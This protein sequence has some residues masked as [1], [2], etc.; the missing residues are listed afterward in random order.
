MTIEIRL[1]EE[2]LKSQ[3]IVVVAGA[4]ISTAAGFPTFVDAETGRYKSSTKDLFDANVST[5][6]QLLKCTSNF[7]ELKDSSKG[8]ILHY[9]LYSQ[10][11][12]NTHKYSQTHTINLGRCNSN[13]SIPQASL[14]GGTTEKNL[15][16]EYRHVGESHAHRSTWFQAPLR[17]NC[18]PSWGHFVLQMLLYL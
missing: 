12:T 7:I 18:I 4:G 2:I 3:S 11:L 6:S 8:L 5:V 9:T 13:S 14:T 17:Q 15:Q 16:P 1:L 10:I